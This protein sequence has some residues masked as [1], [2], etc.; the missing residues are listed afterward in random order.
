MFRAIQFDFIHTAPK[1]NN[2][3]LYIA[4]PDTVKLRLRENPNNQTNPYG[5][6]FGNGEKE[7]PAALNFAH[8]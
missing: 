5:Q 2:S 7:K 4:I 3:H 1:N 6:A 8:V